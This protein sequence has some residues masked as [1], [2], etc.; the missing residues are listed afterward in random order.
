MLLHV[1]SP[2]IHGEEGEDAD[3]DDVRDFNYPTGNQDQKAKLAERMLG[4]HHEQGEDIG[5][6]YDSGEI[7]QNHIPLL[8]HRQ[9]VCLYYLVIHLS[10]HLG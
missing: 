1:G 5:P 4:W 3:V 10:V 7:P 8:T 6:K 9:G 2:P